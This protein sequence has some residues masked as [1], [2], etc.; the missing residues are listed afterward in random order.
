MNEN[1]SIHSCVAFNVEQKITLY[2]KNV[3]IGIVLWIWMLPNLQPQ[4]NYIPN[5]A[6]IPLSRRTSL[7]YV[8]NFLQGKKCGNSFSFGLL[9]SVHV[10]TIKSC[11]NKLYDKLPEYP[12]KAPIKF[13]APHLRAMFQSHRLFWPETYESDSYPKRKRNTNLEHQTRLVIVEWV[14]FN[15]YV[16]TNLTNY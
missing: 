6:T 12:I 14:W 9:W 16:N 3:H 7:T 13:Q 8:V 4:G 10:R 5:W 11:T 2:E 15:L 1:S